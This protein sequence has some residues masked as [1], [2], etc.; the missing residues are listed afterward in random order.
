MS[1]FTLRGKTNVSMQ[2]PRYCLVHNTLKIAIK[3][4]RAR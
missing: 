2:S 4:M 1:R 3:A